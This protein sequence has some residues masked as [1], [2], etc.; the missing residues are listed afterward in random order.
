M[1][2]KKAGVILIFMLVAGASRGRDL[3]FFRK[4]RQGQQ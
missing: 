3:V 4:R 2:K 1:G